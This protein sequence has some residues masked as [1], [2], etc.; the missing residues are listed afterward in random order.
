MQLGYGLG[1]S[2]VRPSKPRFLDWLHP[3]LVA[4]GGGLGW[5]FA[6]DGDNQRAPEYWN[7]SRP[8]NQS[9]MLTTV[10]ASVAT[11][12]DADGTLRTYAVN[13]PV[14]PLGVGLVPRG[15]RTNKN[16]NFN[17]NPIDLTNV[18]LEGGSGGAADPAAMLTL[19]DSPAELEA[20][21]LSLVCASSKVY[22]LNNT[23]VSSATR[24]VLSGI[25]G[26]LNSHA[27][28]CYMRGTGGAQLRFQGGANTAVTL[29]SA[30]QRVS[31]VGTPNAT[32]FQMYV[33]A[34]AGADVYFVLNQLEEGSFVTPPIVTEGASATRLADSLTPPSFEQKV[35]TLELED[36]LAGKAVI[37]LTRLNAASN[38]VIFELGSSQSD[39]IFL[40]IDP[41]NRA[42]VQSNVNGSGYNTI[43]LSSALTL[44]VHTLEFEFVDGA[45]RLSIDDVEVDTD[46]GSY[47]LP[48]LS[49]LYFGNNSVG[50]AALNG[51]I[52]ELQLWKAA[53]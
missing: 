42:T 15:Q 4:A 20:A 52:R 14:I 50:S 12:F 25:P 44:G 32:T 16:T 38:R 29:T 39:R 13:E 2:S 30:F 33:L 45:Y 49:S 26:N 31:V 21:G 36:R 8:G 11:D 22:R 19:V 28:S 27:L 7:V 24:A 18:T 17:A 46:I 6:F 10:R 37:D 43:L 53:A 48:T 41:A 23:G 40:Y 1:V 34:L 51:P 9:N 47:G 5:K 35:A 3:D